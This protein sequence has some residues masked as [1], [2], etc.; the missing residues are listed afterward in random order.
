MNRLS[1]TFPLSLDSSPDGSP[2][3]NHTVPNPTHIAQLG[4]LPTLDGVLPC[5]HSQPNSTRPR[6]YAVALKFGLGSHGHSQ[7]SP[8]E[9]KLRFQFPGSEPSGRPT[10]QTEQHG[11]LSSRPNVMP[12]QGELSSESDPLL[13]MD[14]EEIEGV[15]AKDHADM[16]LN[17]ERLVDRCPWTL[18]RRNELKRVRNELRKM[19]ERRHEEGQRTVS[20]LKKGVR[21]TL[22][23]KEQ[24]SSKA[25]FL[26]AFGPR[27]IVFSLYYAQAIGTSINTDTNNQLYFQKASPTLDQVIL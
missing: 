25:I 17:L 3:H 7:V 10:A 9:P 23:S 19:K 8:P 22:A 1:P 5:H 18:P 16:Y 27:T 12:N 21:I 4:E 14:N 6:R 15:D 20:P 2:D 11:I 24:C 26:T 13:T